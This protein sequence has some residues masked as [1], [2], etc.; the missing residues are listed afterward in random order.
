MANTLNKLGKLTKRDSIPITT[1]SDYYYK[2]EAV[3]KA[4]IEYNLSQYQ[5]DITRWLVKVKEL[6]RIVDLQ[7]GPRETLRIQSRTDYDFREDQQELEYT[8]LQ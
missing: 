8:L 7:L 3:Y 1:L 2:G 5:Q 4:Q 6:A